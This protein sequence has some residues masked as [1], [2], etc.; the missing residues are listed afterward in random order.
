M[1]VNL[2][3]YVD[4]VSGTMIVQLLLA[5]AVGTVLFFR[6]LIVNGVL[7]LT[8]RRKRPDGDSAE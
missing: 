8:G 3:A 2:L 4:P 6:R 7:A 5:G 1:N